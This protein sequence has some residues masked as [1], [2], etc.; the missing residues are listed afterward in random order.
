VPET[1]RRSRVLGRSQTI[2][3]PVNDHLRIDVSDW[4]VVSDETS[5]AD[6]KL[7]V[8]DPASTELWLFKVVTEKNGHRQGEDW[9]EMASSQLAAALGIPCATIQLAVLDGR[10]GVI[11]LDLRPQ[12]FDMQPGFV[13]MQAHPVPG[14][15]PGNVKGRPGHSLSNIQMVLEGVASP[16]D[17]DL[18]VGMDGFGTF[19]GYVMLDALIANRDRHDENWAVLIPTTG[20]GSRRLCGSYDHAGSLGYNVRESE[21][22]RRLAADG[23]GVL[24]WAERG[25]AWR[26][27]HAPGERIPTLV[28]AADHAFELAGPDVREHW[29]GRLNAL[30]RPLGEVAL[31]DIPGLSAPCSTFV[32][33]LLEINRRR[34]LDVC[35]RTA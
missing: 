2:V 18:P 29:V 23:G 20:S 11:S 15:M 21:R 27:E 4:E 8:R 24:E 12:D 31:A 26:L 22:E 6:V 10:D 14:F 30:D 16:P 17:F 5:G 32:S 33:S 9:A 25:T 1:I 7:W 35:S 13:V 34:V 19:C 28:E 3:W